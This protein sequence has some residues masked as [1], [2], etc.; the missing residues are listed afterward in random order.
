MPSADSFRC[1]YC[2]AFFW[3]KAITEPMFQDFMEM[4]CPSHALSVEG[5]TVL[6]VASLII[7]SH[8]R[9]KHL[10]ALSVM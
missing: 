3:M 2:N 8:T 9:G 4:R 1:T 5:A 10:C 6:P 7:Y